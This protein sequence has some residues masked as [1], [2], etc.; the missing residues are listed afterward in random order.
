[1][2]AT[3]WSTYILFQQKQAWRKYAKIRDL[4]YDNGTMFGPCSMEGAYGDYT[5]SFFTAVQQFEDERKNRQL[6]VMQVT[7][8]VPFIDGIAMGTKEMFPFLRTLDAISPHNIESDKWN[9]KNAIRSRNKNAVNAYLTEERIEI[10]TQILNMPN[11]DVLIVLDDKEGVFRFETSN[12]LKNVKQIDSVVNKL[13]ARIKKLQPSP[14]EQ[15]RLISM[16]SMGD[17]NL[18]TSGFVAEPVPQDDASN[19][20]GSLELE[21]EED[22]QEAPI[23]DEASEKVPHEPGGKP[24]EIEYI[25]TKPSKETP[26]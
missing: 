16:K 11:S 14:E 23:K 22:D 26:Q 5:L 4:D 20:A 18:A 17:E 9:K 2:G 24:V 21:I 3:G 6:T 1:L 13:I 10:F 12:P 8:N 15:N 25:N 7:A 19:L